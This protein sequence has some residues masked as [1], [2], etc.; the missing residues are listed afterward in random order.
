MPSLCFSVEGSYTPYTT[1]YTKAKTATMKEVHA[2]GVHVESLYMPTF[3]D[4]IEPSC[5]NIF[6]LAD[7]FVLQMNI[8]ITV[9]PLRC[10]TQDLG[11]VRVLLC[12]LINRK[13]W[14]IS[15]FHLSSTTLKHMVIMSRES[16]NHLSSLT[17]FCD[18]KKNGSNARCILP[19]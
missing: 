1:T 12:Q 8:Y 2:E 3:T 6:H 7:A 5:V 17:P 11:L 15:G 10:R 4:I 9:F 13:P 16:E 14:A 19:L 18:L